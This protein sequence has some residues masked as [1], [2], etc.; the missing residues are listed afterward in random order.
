MSGER[1]TGAPR[2]PVHALRSRRTWNLP[3]WV[4]ALLQLS[5]LL[6]ESLGVNDWPRTLGHLALKKAADESTRVHGG[7]ERRGRIGHSY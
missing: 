6:A 3:A 4:Q 2:D 5:F 7:D 1:G